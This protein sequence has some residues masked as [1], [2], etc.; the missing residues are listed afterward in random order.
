ME[1]NL[2]NVTLRLITINVNCKTTL[3]LKEI[4]YGYRNR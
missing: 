1:S 3:L 2:I 4:N